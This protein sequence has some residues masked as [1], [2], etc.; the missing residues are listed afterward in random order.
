MTDGK[1]KVHPSKL[2]IDGSEDPFYRYKMRQL[3]VQVVGKGKM[4][5]TM[6]VNIDDVARDLKVPPSYLIAF[7]GYHFS[8]S[9]KYEPTKPTR[10]RA[11]VTGNRT[12]NELSATMIKFIRDLV[13][14]PTCG[15][16]ETKI[17][18]G[19]EINC[20]SCGQTTIPNLNDKFKTFITNHPVKEED[21]RSDFNDL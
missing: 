17:C 7:F 3:L 12:L 20:R 11:F 16:P 10:E 1:S 4:I 14:C 6:F 19:I 13:L 21:F 5:K 8:T 2:N 15:L 9:H 18:K